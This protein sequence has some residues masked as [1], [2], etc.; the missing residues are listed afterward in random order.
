MCIGGYLLNDD[1]L[2]EVMTVQGD[3]DEKDIKV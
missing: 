1:R 2:C 3:S